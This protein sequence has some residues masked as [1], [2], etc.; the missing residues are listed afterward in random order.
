[1]TQHQP[2]DPVLADAVAAHLLSGL[3]GAAVYLLT[4]DGRHWFVRKAAATPDGNARLR[5]QAEKQQAWLHLSRG[6]VRTPR[7][8]DQGEFEGRFYFDMEAIRGVDGVT[9]LRSVDYH[10]VAGFADRLCH[11]LDHAAEEPPLGNSA[12]DDLFGSLYDRVCDVQN[13]T[14]LLRDEDAAAVLLGL[15]RLRR[16]GNPPPTLCHGDLTLEN[17]IVDGDGTI[18]AFDLLDAPFE[19][20]WHDVAKLHQDL[21]GGWYLRRQAP[22]ARCITEYLSRR[23]MQVATRRDPHYRE[24]HP[25]FVACTFIRILPYVR[26]QAALAF[27]QQRV[28]HYAQLIR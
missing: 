3:S 10:G 9:Y 11:Y 28:A 15:S 2:H 5:R 18:W 8:L 13:S 7:I 6:D 14:A 16:F 12:S 23:L 24:L 17:L 19:H 26:D 27:V 21:D 4:R 25:L 22:V 20:F 1:M